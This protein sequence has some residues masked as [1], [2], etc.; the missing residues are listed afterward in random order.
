MA[1]AQP[2]R[3]DAAHDP[4]LA[5]RAEFPLAERVTH[6]ISHSLGAMPTRARARAAEYLDAW[7][8]RGIRAWGDGWWAMP[9]EVGDVLADVIG[10]P[11]GSVVMLPNVTTAEAVVLSAVEFSG[12]RNQIVCGALDFPSLLYLYDG[13]ADRGARVLRVPSEDGLTYDA[14]RF[15]D[16]IDETTAVV[17]LSAVIFRSAAIVDVAPIVERAHAVGAMVVVDA[18]Q[19]VG[20]VPLDVTAWGADV[21][22]G[23]SVKYLC[24]GPGAAFL[25]VRPDVLE[26]LRPRLTGW[27][28]HPEPFGFD[29]G[30]MRWRDDMLRFQNG[31]PA[32]P[33]LCTA[34]AGYE[35]VREIGVHAIRAKSQRLTSRIVQFALE[36][37]WTV[38]SPLEAARRGGSVTIG[39]PDPE[40]VHAELDR[41]DVLCDW[42][43]G[44]GIRLGPHF[45]TSDDDV[46]RALSELADVVGEGG[47]AR[48]E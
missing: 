33:A 25:Y 1:T 17:A 7:D 10:A 34:R 3:T 19:W 28:A 27:I 42:R 46:E 26:S 22:V 12:P 39:V 30:P 14:Q 15:V 24:G 40:P 20:T 48:T 29:A 38:N 11:H 8:A 43:P 37:G 23:G 16:A 13:L 31:T 18:Y 36:R 4:L 47:P 45:Y 32:I 21:V 35:I 41:R 2:P 44:V 5:W 6:L 9:I